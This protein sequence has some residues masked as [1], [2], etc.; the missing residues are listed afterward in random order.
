MGFYDENGEYHR[1]AYDDDHLDLEDIGGFCERLAGKAASAEGKP[2]DQ[3]RNAEEIPPKTDEDRLYG[4]IGALIGLVLDFLLGL[5]FGKGYVRV[6]VLVI[7]CNIGARL[8]KTLR[9]DETEVDRK[10]LWRQC[11]ADKTLWYSVAALVLITALRF[12]GTS[13]NGE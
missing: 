3:E 8:W 2:T 5:V 11:L 4:Y 12:S 7:V 13:T 6:F 9:V 10:Q 1:D